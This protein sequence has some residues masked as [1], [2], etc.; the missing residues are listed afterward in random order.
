LGND[1]HSRMGAIQS[2]LYAMVYEE[3]RNF[4]FG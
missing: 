3:K 2:T 4:D 1:W